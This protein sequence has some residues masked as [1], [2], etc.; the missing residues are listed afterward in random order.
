MSFRRG[1]LVRL[2]RDIGDL[3]V[4]TEGFL[5]GFLFDR[6]APACLVWFSTEDEREVSPDDLELVGRHERWVGS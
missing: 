1:D 3:A 6:T 5:L 4:G 2:V